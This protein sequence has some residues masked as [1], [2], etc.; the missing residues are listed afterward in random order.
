LASVHLNKQRQV[1][2]RDVE[3]QGPVSES[4]SEPG[5]VGPSKTAE[6]WVAFAKVGVFQLGADAPVEKVQKNIALIAEGI[7]SRRRAGGVQIKEAVRSHGSMEAAWIAMLREIGD[8]GPNE[9]ATVG[10]LGLADGAVNGYRS[11]DGKKGWRIDFDPK[12]GTH[13][14]WYDWSS[15]KAGQGGRWGAE[16]FT[17]GEAEFVDYL[18]A[19]DK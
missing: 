13:L 16:R 10:K 8:V 1:E 15:G 3:S 12:K 17:G 7:Q 2:R 9:V 5:V 19:L 18:L 6:A 4:K 14:N 11:A